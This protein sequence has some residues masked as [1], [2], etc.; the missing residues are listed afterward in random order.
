MSY[1]LGKN[2]DFNPNNIFNNNNLI[3]SNPPSNPINKQF[4]DDKDPLDRKY[5]RYHSNKKG[6]DEG[7]NDKIKSAGVGDLV[8]KNCIN[9]VF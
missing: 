6:K 9:L 8:S 4:Q 3:I 1:N 2:F 7:V 5:F